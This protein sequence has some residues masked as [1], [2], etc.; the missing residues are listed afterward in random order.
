VGGGYVLN[1]TKNRLVDALERHVDGL[2]LFLASAH[3]GAPRLSKVTRYRCMAFHRLEF[4][5][6]WT[7]QMAGW[8]PL[9]GTGVRFTGLDAFVVLKYA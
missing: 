2:A 8:R 7:F 6:V 4:S 3:Q 5:L 9:L 1:A